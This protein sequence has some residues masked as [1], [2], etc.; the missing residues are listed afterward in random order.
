MS[1]LLKNI[2]QLFVVCV[3]SSKTLIKTLCRGE[4][5]QR[6][7]SLGQCFSTTVYLL[8]PMHPTSQGFMFH[9][10]YL[11]SAATLNMCFRLYLV[12]AFRT[13][14]LIHN[15]FFLFNQ[16]ATNKSISLYY[17]QIFLFSPQV[18]QSVVTTFS[19]T[20]NVC[21]KTENILLAKDFMSQKKRITVNP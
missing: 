8:Y 20:T 10:S 12:A 15:P 4:Q 9:S 2:V 17:A 3:P 18:C 13:T 1:I 16:S 14:S 7:P 6:T 19:S 11:K 5:N 21:C